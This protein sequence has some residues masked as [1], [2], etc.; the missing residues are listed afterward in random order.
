M[1]VALN[2]VLNQS[3]PFWIGAGAITVALII[4]GT[5]NHKV[6]RS[7]MAALESAR[8]E[9]V[10]YREPDQRQSFVERWGQTAFATDQQ[11]TSSFAKNAQ[12]VRSAQ[13][14]AQAEAGLALAYASAGNGPGFSLAALHSEPVTVDVAE[15]EEDRAALAKMD[16]VERYLWEAYKRAPIKKDGAG[17]FT[18]KDPMAAKRFGLSMPAYV[19]SGMD[20]DFREQV[21]HMGKAMDAAGIKWVILSAFRD[22]YRQSLASGFKASPRNSLHGGS[23]R[24]GG[25][26]HGRAVDVIGA[27]DNTEDVWKWIDANGGKYGLHRPMPGAD[28][29]HIQSRGDWR[30]LAQGLREAR[31]TIAQAQGAKEAAKGK[32][33]NATR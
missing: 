17:D 4:F 15:S 24:T 3:A 9:T 31:L 21:Y 23:A 5:V 19:I 27:E 32:V 1:T 28:P 8:S 22:D 12:L 26:G 18:W 29:G 13:A 14:S 16:E 11:N 2:V 7:A 33:A 30:K 10:V 25:F 20:R 6:S